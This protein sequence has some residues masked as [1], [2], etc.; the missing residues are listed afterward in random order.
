MKKNNRKCIICGKEYSFC[1]NCNDDA[2]KPYWYINYCD[3]NC[4]KIYEACAGFSA[5]QYDKKATA[6][7]LKNCDL[8]NM[9]HFDDTI[10][11]IINVVMKEENSADTPEKKYRSQKKIRK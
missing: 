3:E 8:S 5:K 2:G 9:D 10:K 1:P 7:R 4:K 6:Q 11:E